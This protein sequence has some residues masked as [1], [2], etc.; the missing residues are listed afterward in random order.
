M[1]DF[2]RG[3]GSAIKSFSLELDFILEEPALH[4]S[5][6]LSFAKQ[7]FKNNTSS[8]SN[9]SKGCVLCPTGTHSRASWPA[10]ASKKLF[11]DKGR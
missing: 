5:D 7:D 11:K 4:P 8:F 1:W 10:Y 3:R 6:N 2:Q 9:I